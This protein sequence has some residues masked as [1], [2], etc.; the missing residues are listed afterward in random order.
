MAT[1]TRTTTPKLSPSSGPPTIVQV[2]SNPLATQDPAL[3]R[4][5][6][7]TLLEVLAPEDLGSVEVRFRVCEDGG[8][9]VRFICKV[10]N[11]PANDLDPPTRQQWRWWSPLMESLQDFRAALQDAV[12]VRRERSTQPVSAS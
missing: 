2:L 1:A 7:S 11:P 10:E 9:G 6:E 8:D 5:V 12:Q 3:A 4:A